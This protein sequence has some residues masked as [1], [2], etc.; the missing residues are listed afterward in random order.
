MT[1]K[2]A[3]MVPMIRYWKDA[4]SARRWE[5]SYS[6]HHESGE[7]EIELTGAP[8]AINSEGEQSAPQASLAVKPA[9]VSEISSPCVALVGWSEKPARR[10]RKDRLV[11]W[12][13]EA[14][15]PFSA[16]QR[17]WES[18]RESLPATLSVPRLARAMAM[19]LTGHVLRT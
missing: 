4:V 9:P 11:A 14:L 6:P 16:L 10:V 15:R 2:V 13:K 19:L 18:F 17:S 3:P 7:D 5:G 1:M 12:K 8:T